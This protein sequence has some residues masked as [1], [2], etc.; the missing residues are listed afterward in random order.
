MY[1]PFYVEKHIWV[2]YWMLVIFQWMVQPGWTGVSD[3]PPIDYQWNWNQGLSKDFLMSLPSKTNCY[4][5]I[6]RTGFPKQLQTSLDILWFIPGL[7]QPVDAAVVTG[8]DRVWGGFG[9][10]IIKIY[11]YKTKNLEEVRVVCWNRIGVVKPGTGA[12]ASDFATPLW[13]PYALIWRTD[14]SN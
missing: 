7:V 14:P 12:R 13:M 3:C 10:S 4:K 5:W 6:W 9:T 11:C 1:V 2:P 8:R